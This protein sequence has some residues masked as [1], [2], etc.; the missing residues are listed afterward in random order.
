MG[1]QIKSG[2]SMRVK[3]DGPNGNQKTQNG[4][5]AKVEG[6]K[7]KNL[8]ASKDEPGRSLLVNGR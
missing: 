1:G 8:V 5:S 7:G 6:L 3:L 2:R 4:W